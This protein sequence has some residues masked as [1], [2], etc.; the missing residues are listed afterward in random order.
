[1]I[2]I[3]MLDMALHYNRNEQL[4]YVTM[5]PRKPDIRT[6]SLVNNKLMI[7][8]KLTHHQLPSL[9]LFD[10]MTLPVATSSYQIEGEWD[11]VAY[12]KNRGPKL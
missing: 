4:Q 6:F 9:L 8:T 7:H 12:I 3:L 2:A 11:A 10:T 1:M 5:M